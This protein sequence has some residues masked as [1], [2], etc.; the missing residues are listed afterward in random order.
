MEK[1]ES[2]AYYSSFLQLIGDLQGIY[3]QSS[4]QLKV[5]LYQL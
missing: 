5:V 3:H 2:D 4:F 1:L